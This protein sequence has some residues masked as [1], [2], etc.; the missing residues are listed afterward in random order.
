MR[1]S[2]P[3]ASLAAPLAG[4]SSG[5]RETRPASG[6]AKLSIVA[7][8]LLLT[9]ALAYGCE[10]AYPFAHVATE[11]PASRPVEP[12]RFEYHALK[13]GS[14]FNLVLYAPDRSTADAARDAVFAWVDQLAKVFSDGEYDAT[15]EISQLNLRAH[16]APMAQPAAVSQDLWNVLE[17]SKSAFDA[18]GGAF[19]ITV[20][21]Y[22]Q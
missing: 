6:A 2:A 18:S 8:G 3:R 16:A 12:Q 5:A 15:S 20:G 22:V 10:P 17:A 4:R 14:D 21:P 9:L 11:P 19:D 13:M 1:V 7:A